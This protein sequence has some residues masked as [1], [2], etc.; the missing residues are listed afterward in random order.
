MPSPYPTE[1][2]A[3][4]PIFATPLAEEHSTARQQH[5]PA[6]VFSPHAPLHSAGVTFS[7]QDAQDARHTPFA[8][9]SEQA[10]RE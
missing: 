8:R 1:L 9:L 7:S 10:Q 2:A 5:S 6:D 4:A 3:V